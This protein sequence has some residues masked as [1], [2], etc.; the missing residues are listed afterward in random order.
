MRPPRT[1]RTQSAGVHGRLHRVHEEDEW[2][3]L[4]SRAALKAVAPNAMPGAALASYARW[5]QLE[6]WLRELVYVELRALYGQ[7]WQAAVKA[8]LDR[9]VADQAF[10]HMAAADTQNPLAYLDYSQLASIIA[11]HWPQLEPSLITKASWDGRQEDLK[12]IRHR[13]GHVRRPHTDDLNRL[14]QTL[15]DL[16]RGAFI[17]L[18]SYNRRTMPDST[19]HKGAVTDGWIRGRHE[20]ARRLI[21]HAERQYDTRL[22]VRA[23]RRPWCP[24]IPADLD[25]AEGVLWHADFYLRGGLVDARRLWHDSQLD[26]LRPLLVHLLADWPAHISFT[27]AAKDD[28]SEVADAIGDAFDAVLMVMDRGAWD[29][30]D[31]DQWRARARGVDFRVLHGTGWNIVDDS[32]LPISNFG[33]GGGVE[34]APSW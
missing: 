20:V 7:H 13:I 9:Q 26:R 5:W 1:E 27:F 14:E 23:S 25:G 4:D 31:L 3:D 8:S 24:R 28:G 33:A 30:D 22:V 10:T 18:A 34:S 16:E 11:G 32:T 17:A 19:H 21:D 6:A 2:L 29:D 12:R 15:R